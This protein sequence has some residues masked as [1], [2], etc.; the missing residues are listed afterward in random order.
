MHAEKKMP[1]NGQLH[2]ICD[3]EF[4]RPNDTTVAA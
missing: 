4:G 1:R 2:S 3:N